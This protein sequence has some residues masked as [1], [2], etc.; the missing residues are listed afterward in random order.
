V[1]PI[2]RAMLATQGQNQVLHLNSEF[3]KTWLYWKNS[4]SIDDFITDVIMW[5]NAT[6]VNEKFNSLIKI[7][8]L[9]I[10]NCSL[11]FNGA[12]KE[13]KFT[14]NDQTSTR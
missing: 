1:Q 6:F 7:Y 12:G 5:A 3:L 2:T 10:I 9:K 4:T 14:L 11:F 8:F 13:N